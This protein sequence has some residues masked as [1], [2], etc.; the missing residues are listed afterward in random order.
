MVPKSSRDPTREKTTNAHSQTDGRTETNETADMQ[1]HTGTE[2]KICPHHS[3]ALCAS[4]I[5]APSRLGSARGGEGRGE[6]GGRP[7]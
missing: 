4:H 6:G 7:V 3:T 1:T 5:C 2:M